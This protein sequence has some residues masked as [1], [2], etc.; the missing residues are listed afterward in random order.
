MTL[1]LMLVSD[2]TAIEKVLLHN[3]SLLLLDDSLVSFLVYYS[4]AAL[5]P[6][7]NT[8]ITAILIEGII[9]LALAVTGAR[10]LIA[11]WI[12][13]PVRQATP[14]AIGAFLAHLGLQTAE[15]LGIVVAD[16]ATSV[17][18]GGCPVSKRTPMVQ[19]DAGCSSNPDFCVTSDAYTC[20][21]EGGIMTSGTT[22]AGIVGLLVMLA[23]LCYKN[24]A[25]FVVGISL[26]TFVSWFRNSPFT[27]FPDTPVGDERFDY[28]KQ[29]VS[30]EKL[31]KLL[32]N[33]TSDLNDAG[34][35]LFTL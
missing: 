22:W 6:L 3:N 17:T 1:P 16:V 32:V 11:K 27:Y 33:F 18:L 12:P 26:V 34:V 19:F 8:A 7:S 30:V 20:D 13:E 23:L 14:A 4:T 2:C 28:F 29:V 9:F 10:Q 25:A 35:A 21:V 31:D 24:Q 15:G 5:R